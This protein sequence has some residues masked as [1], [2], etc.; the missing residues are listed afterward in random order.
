MIANTTPFG[1]AAL[2]G[3]P[4]H[5]HIHVSNAEEAMKPKVCVTTMYLRLTLRG[6]CDISGNTSN[7]LAPE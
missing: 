1:S 6:V 7:W 2:T 5:V 3:C 4:L